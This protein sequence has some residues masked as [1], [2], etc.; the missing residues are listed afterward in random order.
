MEMKI[1]EK[2]NKA[3]ALLLVLGLSYFAVPV[4]Q[5]SAIMA[6]AE[7]YISKYIEGSSNNKAIEIYNSNDSAIDFAAGGYNIKMYF[8]GNV[9]PGL[10]INLTGTV[11]SG[12]VYVIAHSSA[13]GSILAQ[14]DQ[15]NSSGW[16][17]GDDALVLY[18]GTDEIDSIGQV[19]V[20]PG[21]EW[22]TGLTS[23]ADNTL[24]R[25]CSITTGDIDPT[26]IY[27]PSL[28]WDGYA[29]D[30]ITNLGSYF[31]DVISPTVSITSSQAN[32]T[33][34]S[35]INM[36]AVFSE[37]VIG[38]VVADLTISNGVASNFIAVDSTTYTF[39]V[40][41]TSQGE[42]TVD[43]VADAAEDAADNGNI[44]A[45]QYSIIYDTVNPI[46]SDQTATNLEF[47]PSIVDGVKDSTDLKY[48]LSEDAK[49]T[50]DIYN[51]SDVLVRS[52]ISDED[53]LMG[54]NQDTWDGKDNAPI[55]AF[56]ADGYYWARL[57]AKD[58][59]GNQALKKD[60]YDIYVDNTKPVVADM[61]D[62]VTNVP[63]N[64]SGSATDTSGT[65]INYNWVQIDGPAG[66][67]VNFD[68][69]IDPATL[70]SADMDGEYTLELT[71]A[72]KAG[73]SDSKQIKFL[74]DATVNPVTDH[75]AVTGDSFVDLHWS[76]PSDTDLVSV[77]IYRST[78][79][80]ETG[81]LMDELILGEE[82]YSDNLV[83][84]G[85]TY[86][87][88][89]RTVDALGN[90]A[91]ANIL[92]VTPESPTFGSVFVPQVA[93][94]EFLPTGGPENPDILGDQAA[95]GEVKSGETNQDNNDSEED[96]NSALPAVGIALLVI[97]AL[98]GLYLL[99][100]QN[101]EWFSKLMFWKKK[102]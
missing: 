58:D 57:S 25:K 85:T 9:T 39:D 95:D 31:C 17:N 100:L 99:Y 90:T 12:D 69:A 52:L 59:A 23:S 74:W 86:Y 82:Q 48:T 87:Y 97:L 50:I 92:K 42:V 47:S 29:T 8:N 93:S 26:D 22:G 10:T 88:T 62:I 11:T 55:S 67:T 14:A 24:V 76:N 80:G 54:V 37:D 3:V 61:L 43:I 66:G 79:A 102:K 89:I 101:P 1:K 19:G 15:T 33:N 65:E 13:N 56:V 27:N 72:D 64:L 84:N 94:T 38:F 81:V 44:A 36:I 7:P 78:V 5:A 28:E 20:D 46:I 70:T 16:Y 45:T 71:A 83:L 18:K 98:V 6:V 49:V 96:D 30:T 60:V 77:Q 34:I 51:D 63:I 75:Y 68:N 2:I 91:D 32:P 21:S 41:P 40:T 53:K 73:N 4:K 35:P